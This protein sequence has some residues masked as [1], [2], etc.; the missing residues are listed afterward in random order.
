MSS[1]HFAWLVDGIDGKPHQLDA[2][3]VEFRLQ[4]G[5]RAEFGGADR[6]EILRMREQQRPAV[7]DPVVE[8]DLAFG[9][10]GLEI[11]GHSAYLESHVSTSCRSSYRGILRPKY[12]GRKR[13]S[14]WPWKKGDILLRQRELLASSLAP[15]LCGKKATTAANVPCAPILPLIALITPA[16]G[17]DTEP[18]T[19]VMAT[20]R[21]PSKKPA[22][23]VSNR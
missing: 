8:F 5:Q 14:E 17:S 6:G 16:A 19:A 10:F 9:G 23:R 20:N 1:D 18:P 22:M 7:A 3:L 2:A 13:L 4:P 21:Q 11:R 12:R 15:R